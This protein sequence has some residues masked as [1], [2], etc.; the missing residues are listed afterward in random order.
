MDI[1][2]SF[3]LDVRLFLFQL[4]NFVLVAAILWWLILKPL[5]KKLEERKNVIDQS[6]D[7]AEKIQGRLAASE[8]DYK[9]RMHAARVEAEKVLIAAANEAGAVSEE[10][11]AK[12]RVEIERLVA[13]AKRTVQAEKEEM[14]AAFKEEAAGVVGAA[15]EKLIGEKMTAEKDKKLIAGIISKLKA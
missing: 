7:N 3:G 14:M 1:L 5:A 13:Q 4:G 10:L 9:K 12:A 6:L 2:A 8:A 15:L 11:K